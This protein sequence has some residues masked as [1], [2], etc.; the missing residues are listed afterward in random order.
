MKSLI[1]DY[2]TLSN[3]FFNGVVV[4]LASLHFEESRFIDNPYEYEELLA[5]PNLL[6]L[7]Y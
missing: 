6:S 3:D 4:N 1:Y 7:M 5:L 2:E